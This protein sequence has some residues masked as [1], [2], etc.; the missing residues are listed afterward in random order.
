MHFEGHVTI[1]APRQ[2]VWEF[3]TDPNGVSQCVPGLESLDIVEPNQ[4][5]K[6]VASIGLGTVKAR[7]ST[8]VEWTELD[9]PNR[10]RMKAHGKAPGSAMDTVSEM[11]LSDGADGTTEMA[12]SAEVTIRGSIAS[13]A[14][15]MLGGVTKKLTSA[16]FEC[17]R[18]KIEA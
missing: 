8:D 10:A 7:F 12:W 15:R 11:I 5:F 16:F 2:K 1:K 18:K 13:L 4:K 17:V 9:P 14:A 3:L 6:A